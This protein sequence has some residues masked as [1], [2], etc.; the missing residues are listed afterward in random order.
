MS[1]RQGFYDLLSELQ[2]EKNRDT[3]AVFEKIQ[4]QY[5][6]RHQ[7]Y[8]NFSLTA[9]QQNVL[10][11]LHT[12][13]EAFVKLYS[14]KNLFSIDPVMQSA[15]TGIKPVDWRERHLSDPATGKVFMIAAGFGISD[16]G[17]T[18]PLLCR[19]SQTALFVL[20]ADL[21]P[22]KW[23]QRRMEILR[24]V[25]VLATYLH[26]ARQ[27]LAQ[28]FEPAELTARESE[29]LTWTAAGKSYWEISMILGISERT[30]RFFMTNARRKLGVVTNPQAVAQAVWRGIIPL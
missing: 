27:E 28:A 16:I 29:V 30:V 25:Q 6:I 11:L 21:A 10:D 20:N 14:E 24:D 22:E 7:A 18:I 2:Q 8:I 1:R 19:G 15:L 4:A 12:F 23:S 9:G 26:A 13:P 5:E 17:M 3:D